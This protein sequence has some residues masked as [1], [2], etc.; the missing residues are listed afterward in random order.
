MSEQHEGVGP[1]TDTPTQQ[2]PTA[3]LRITDTTDSIVV[4]DWR[5]IRL[6]SGKTRPRTPGEI[7]AASA[8]VYG[9]QDGYRAGYRAGR[10]DAQ[11]RDDQFT[12]GYEAGRAQG[13][14]EATFWTLQH[15]EPS[16]RHARR[17]ARRDATRIRRANRRRRTDTWHGID[18]LNRDQRRQQYRELIGSWSGPST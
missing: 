14:R 9:L 8:Y 11:A 7:P 15:L 4:N 18:E 12:A 3:T 10:E 5:P 16:R 2:A 17:L 6:P 13:W 1:T